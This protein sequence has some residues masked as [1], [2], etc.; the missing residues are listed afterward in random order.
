MALLKKGFF[1]G[2]NMTAPTLENS[3]LASTGNPQTDTDIEDVPSN[4]DD[5]NYINII[6]ED[7]KQLRTFKWI[8]FIV[9][10]LFSCLFLAIGL[11]K[12][13]KFVDTQLTLANETIIINKKQIELDEKKLELL[14]NKSIKAADIEKLKLS[15]TQDEKP[16]NNK[17]LSTGIILTLITIIFA[18]ALTILLNLMKHSFHDLQKK[19]DTDKP[20]VT[21]PV[22]DLIIDFITWIK[23]KFGSK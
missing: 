8:I 19:E 21:T 12:S 10:I 9:G 1:L 2:L 13:W 7:R 16:I 4:N 5:P 14:K 20:S 6:A 18:V 3:P 23:D 17:V 22:S 11:C 15:Y